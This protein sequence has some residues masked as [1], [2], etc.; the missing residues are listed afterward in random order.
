MFSFVYCLI[1][2]LLFISSF[3]LFWVLLG[4]DRSSAF[5]TILQY[6]LGLVLD[7]VILSSLNFPISEIFAVDF[8]I[9]TVMR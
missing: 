7:N 9:I 2:T 1:N 4:F 5:A 8:L 3:D 6:T